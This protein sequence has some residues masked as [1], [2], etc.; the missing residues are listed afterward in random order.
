MLRPQTMAGARLT[1]R[2]GAVLILIA[3]LGMGQ[4]AHGDLIAYWNF[5]EPAGATALQD[6]VGPADAVAASAGNLPMAGQP[7]I[8]GGGWSFD[9]SD[10]N[11]LAV[12]AAAGD[13]AAFV[14]LGFSGWSYSG[15]INTTSLDGADTI[16]SI[17]DAAAGSE[18][19]ALRLTG[20]LVNFLGRHNSNPNVDI[21]GTTNVSDGEWHHLAVASDA[22]G[23]ILYVNGVAEASTGDGVDIATFTTNA[24]N[25]SVNFGA[26]NDNAPNLQWEYAGLIDEFRVYN[27]KLSA[28]EVAVLAIPEPNSLLLL[29]LAALVARRR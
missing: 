9:G 16:F 26:N 10:D 7:G 29:G 17:S 14:P 2:V 23:T 27:H 22:S 18:E 8:F 28:A 21:T 24:G 3:G 12:D 13:N 25:I 5:D 4:V 11:R 1:Q 15:W 19:A 6:Q 20:G